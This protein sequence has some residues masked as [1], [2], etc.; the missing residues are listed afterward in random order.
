MDGL[1]FELTSMKIDLR[2]VPQDQTFP[3]EPVFY[4]FNGQSEVCDEV[5]AGYKVNN[6]L[7]RSL[8]HTNVKLTWD[9][10]NTERLY[11]I[12]TSRLGFI[13]EKLLKSDEAMNRIDWSQYIDCESDEEPDTKIDIWNNT[14]IG[15]PD[16]DKSKKNK[17]F[18][19]EISFNP[20]F[21]DLGNAILEK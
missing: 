1:E 14:K 9:E 17:G 10:P 19:L 3:N 18:D 21:E 15:N 6:F 7:N 5:A 12:L 4:Y 20:A 16:F 2:I 13:N 8:N 11:F